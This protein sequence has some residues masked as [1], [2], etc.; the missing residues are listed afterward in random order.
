LVA[1][2]LEFQSPESQPNHLDVTK[3]S[4]KLASMGA[5]NDDHSRAIIWSPILFMNMLQVDV[6]G[7]IINEERAMSPYKQQFTQSN[8]DGVSCN[9]CTYYGQCRNYL[10]ETLWM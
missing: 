10:F 2:S 9:G 5:P 3:E 4:P 8:L 1:Q 7:D 6:V